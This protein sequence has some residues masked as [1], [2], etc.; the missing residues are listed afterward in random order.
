MIAKLHWE[1][2]RV[3]DDAIEY[4]LLEFFWSEKLTTCE[5]NRWKLF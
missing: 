3:D 2:Q 1:A 5:D 4:F